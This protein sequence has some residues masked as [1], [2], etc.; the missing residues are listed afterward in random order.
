MSRYSH[1]C[2]EQTGSTRRWTRACALAAAEQADDW[3]EAGVIHNNR[4]GIYRGAC[5]LDGA[6]PHSELAVTAFEAVGYRRGVARRVGADE[7]GE[8]APR[9]RAVRQGVRAV[10]VD[11]RRARAP[12]RSLR[13]HLPV[14]DL[15]YA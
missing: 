5:R 2:R 7:R 3:Q 9:R 13:P 6:L 8:R 10:P 4:S 11:A 14:S 1:L 12:P 15:D